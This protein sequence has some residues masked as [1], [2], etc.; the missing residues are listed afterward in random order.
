MIFA[1]I[2]HRRVNILEILLQTIKGFICK[3]S[4]INFKLTNFKKKISLWE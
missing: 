3:L 1:Q 2:V 4:P